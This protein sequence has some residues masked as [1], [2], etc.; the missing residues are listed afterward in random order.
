MKVIGKKYVKMCQTISRATLVQ[1]IAKNRDDIRMTTIHGT[2]KKTQD[3]W[4]TYASDMARN[5]ENDA[6]TT[7]M[8]IMS[9]MST[10]EYGNVM[11]P[12]ENVATC[13]SVWQIAISNF[14]DSN[15]EEELFLLQNAVSKTTGLLGH[16]EISSVDNHRFGYVPKFNPGANRNHYG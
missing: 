10:V 2:R 16:S 1:L 14:A 5:L 8:L 9:T 3:W 12:C 15:S 4:H 6:R 7:F 11:W 13:C